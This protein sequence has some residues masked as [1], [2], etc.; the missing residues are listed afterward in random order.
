MVR[1]KTWSRALENVMMDVIV[2]VSPPHAHTNT[3]PG[4]HVGN[5]NSNVLP[6]GLSTASVRLFVC[7]FIVYLLCFMSIAHFNYILLWKLKVKIKHLLN[8]IF[9]LQS[10]QLYK[11]IIGLCCTNTVKEPNLG[12]LYTFV[13]SYHG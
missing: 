12:S 5:Q 11:M 7:E 2:I 13:H 10:V 1:E 3:V 6:W 8:R 4:I 9:V